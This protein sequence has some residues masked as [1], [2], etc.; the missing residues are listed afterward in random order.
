MDAGIFKLKGGFTILNWKLDWKEKIT[1]NKSKFNF[2]TVEIIRFS[3]TKL[4][5][6]DANFTKFEI[7][8]VF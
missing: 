2:S 8:W 6:K 3:K 4:E 7:V 1:K 5:W